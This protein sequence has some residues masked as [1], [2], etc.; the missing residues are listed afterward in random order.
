[1]A[2]DLPSADVLRVVSLAAEADYPS[3]ATNGAGTPVNAGMWVGSVFD[4]NVP[5][6]LDWVMAWKDSHGNPIVRPDGKPVHD[7]VQGYFSTDLELYFYRAAACVDA[8]KES[9]LYARY[10]GQEG[11]GWQAACATD[12]KE[13]NDILNAS[14]TNNRTT[15]MMN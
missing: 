4:S 3:D 10:P 6:T 9:D 8:S 11:S 2:W 7:L 1:M 13:L 14:K 12:T 15:Y 5:K